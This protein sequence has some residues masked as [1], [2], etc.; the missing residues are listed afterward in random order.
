MLNAYVTYNEEWNPKP[1]D[2]LSQDRE[3]DDDSDD[4][5]LL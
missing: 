2:T 3:D 1:N 5:S 4:D